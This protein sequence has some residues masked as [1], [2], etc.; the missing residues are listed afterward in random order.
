M[1]GIERHG[2]Q[3]AVRA[4]SA[5]PKPTATER[6][7][8]PRL[9]SYTMDLINNPSPAIGARSSGSPVLIAAQKRGS[10]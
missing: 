9:I 5:F 8:T 4:G 3:L 2:V 6:D 10:K 1:P 7:V